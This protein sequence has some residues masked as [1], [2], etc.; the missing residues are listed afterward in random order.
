M[1]LPTARSAELVRDDA[2]ERE[3]AAR[4]F[5]EDQNRGKDQFL[6]TVAH[7]LRQ[8]LFPMLAALELMKRR[9]SRES[10]EHARQVIEKQLGQ[11]MRLIEDLMDAAR[12]RERKEQLRADRADLRDVVK[13]AIEAVDPLVRAKR[14]LVTLVAPDTGVWV[15]VD[16]ARI[17]QV[18][19]NLLSNASKFSGKRSPVTITI[20]F[21]GTNVSVAIQDQGRGIPPDVLPHIFE[22][23]RQSTAGECGGLGIGLFI[24][25]K[26]VELH[27][28]AVEARSA[29]PDRGSVFTV[30][31]PL[32]N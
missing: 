29:G 17:Q 23:F 25:R 6:A 21:E 26:V 14:Q 31:L 32:A 28:G 27:G 8:P 15:N 19:T 22:I 30:R 3:R 1:K 11:L 10:G 9:E 2:L 13:D 24:V 5:A 18:F 7:E 12:L 20:G 4:R 16:A